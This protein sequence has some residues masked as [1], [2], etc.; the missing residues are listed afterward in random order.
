MANA[1]SNVVE[2]L[3]ERGSVVPTALGEITTRNLWRRANITEKIGPV[4]ILQGSATVRG[5][6]VAG[7]LE[8]S[9]APSRHI[10]DRA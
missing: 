3:D 9:R 6:Y 5:T 4:E 1:S 2:L 10:E 7:G 8:Q